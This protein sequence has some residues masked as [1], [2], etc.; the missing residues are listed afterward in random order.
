[1]A[2]PYQTGPALVT[3]LLA[4]LDSIKE[5]AGKA[6]ILLRTRRKRLTDLAVELGRPFEHEL[7]LNTLRARQ[8]ELI[9][10]LDLTKDE[11]GSH[12]ADADVALAAA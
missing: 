1:E 10:Q 5:L 3:G 7:R 9:E 4:T 8:T 6:T 2:T 11:A 12:K